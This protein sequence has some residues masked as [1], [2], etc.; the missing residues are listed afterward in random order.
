MT[1]WSDRF[2][3]FLAADH[4]SMRSLLMQGLTTSIFEAI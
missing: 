2:G 4:A 3:P 1:T